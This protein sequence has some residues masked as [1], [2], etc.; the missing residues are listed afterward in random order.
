MRQAGKEKY[1][2]SIFSCAQLAGQMKFLF[3][4]GFA[5]AIKLI[6]TTNSKQTFSNFDVFDSFKQQN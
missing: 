6:V 3:F 5:L 4:Q 2:I 1:T